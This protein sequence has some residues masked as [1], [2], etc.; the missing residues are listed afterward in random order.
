MVS[1]FLKTKLLINFG[2]EKVHTIRTRPKRKNEVEGID[3]YFMTSEELDNLQMQNK[4]AYR[5]EVFGGEYAYLKDEIFS[6]KNMVFEMHYTTIDD[7]KKVRPDIK[8][9]YIFPSDIEKAKIQIKNRGLSSIAEISRL[10]EIIEQYNFMINNKN[11]QSKFDYIFFN[12]Y[13]VESEN[14]L[15]NLVSNLS[16]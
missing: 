13:D 16:K 2:F 11:F 14:K 3:G 12:N 8:T 5:F 15:I 6:N 9:I 7:W 4:I 1:P 10:N